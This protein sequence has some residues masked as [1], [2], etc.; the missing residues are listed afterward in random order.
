MQSALVGRTIEQAAVAALVQRA[1]GGR[2]QPILVSG[3][4]GCGKTTM[5]RHAVAE[6]RRTGFRA[7]TIDADSIDGG[8]PFAAL[9]LAVS[10]WSRSAERDLPESSHHLDELRSSLAAA[11]QSTDRAAVAALAQELLE[12]WAFH[13]PV[14][15]AVDDLHCA[16]SATVAVVLHLIRAVRSHRVL[17]AV[18]ARP[19]PDLVAEIDDE[20][21]RLAKD[22]KLDVIEL[23]PFS[24]AELAALAELHLGRPPGRELV[25]LLRERTGGLPFYAAE[26][27]SALSEA[28]GAEELADT[29]VTET[30]MPRR[31]A[32]AVLARIARAGPDAARFASA[33]AVLGEVDASRTTMIA[34]LSGLSDDRVSEA[35]AS[36]VERG[37]MVGD[38]PRL[39]FRHAIVRDALY[40]DIGPAERRRRHGEIARQLAAA[41]PTPHPQT[42]L[43]IAGHL[44]RAG[45][46][47]DEFSHS[48]FSAAG[49]VVEPSSPAAAVAWYRL[50]LANLAPVRLA[51]RRRPTA[52]EP[53]ARAQLRL[54][55]SRPDREGGAPGGG[56]GAAAG[57]L[58]RDRRRRGLGG[59]RPRRRRGDARR[60]DRALGVRRAPRSTCR[61]A[62]GPRGVRPS[63]RPPRTHRSARA[64]RTSAVGGCRGRPAALH[65][66]G[67]FALA[68][69]L[70]AELAGRTVTDGP[71][72]ATTRLALALVA[73]FSGD[74]S[75]AMGWLGPHVAGAT[76]PDGPLR[77]WAS[78]VLRSLASA[79]VV[80]PTRRSWP[81]QRNGSRRAATWPSLS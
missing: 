52:V 43:E 7:L 22:G 15:L 44:R 80:S 24:D 34:A 73:A 39:R 8:L 5:L 63:E 70:A 41:S 65:A 3:E 69:D 2:P 55:R 6:C 47:R 28:G 59:G 19:A 45:G 29:T 9:R 31:L 33:A 35:V 25:P 42:T 51:R 40:D 49:A 14:L 11:P 30:V 1:R 36:L 16:D 66:V 4:A 21:A 26:L 50:A 58:G 71:L 53:G 37:I 54:R 67:D 61:G 12:D 79:R 60:G 18:T 78:A 62:C 20:I 32:T 64:G 56:T 46:G 81:K 10:E 76:A 72:D 17:V 23:G 48:V 68:S 77:P 57:R 75:M 38:G 74:P 27:L 13:G